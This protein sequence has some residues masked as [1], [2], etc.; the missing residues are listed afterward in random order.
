MIKNELLQEEILK[1]QV[2]LLVRL[3]VILNF[4]LNFISCQSLF[5]RSPLNLCDI[6][7]YFIN[8]SGE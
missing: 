6:I 1:V 7:N 2:F 4:V 8:H 3:D 5:Q